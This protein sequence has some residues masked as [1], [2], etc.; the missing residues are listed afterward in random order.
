MNDLVDAMDHIDPEPEEQPLPEER[1]SAVK[2]R[3]PAWNALRRTL[4]EAE[5][6]VVRQPESPGWMQKPLRPPGKR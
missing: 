6:R 5:K 1:K 2:R 4:P 3:Q